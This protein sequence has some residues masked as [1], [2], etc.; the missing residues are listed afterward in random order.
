MTIENEEEKQLQDL[1]SIREQFENASIQYQN[2]RDKQSFRILG[3]LSGGLLA[4]IGL[5]LGQNWPIRLAV[6][7]CGVL[8]LTF[9]LYFISKVSQIDLDQKEAEVRS[10]RDQLDAAHRKQNKGFWKEK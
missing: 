4:L 8:I 6:F 9:S 10:L 1:S 7:L 2:L 3:S 5:I